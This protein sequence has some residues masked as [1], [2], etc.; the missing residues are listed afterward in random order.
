[1]KKFTE[2]KMNIVSVAMDENIASSSEECSLGNK[3]TATQQK[4]Q[5]CKLYHHKYGSHPEGI[6][7][8]SGIDTFNKTYDLGYADKNSALAAADS[9][10]CPEGQI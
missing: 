5:N 2:P 9:F 1:M 7:Y 4:C 6:D 3:Y 10:G 8:S